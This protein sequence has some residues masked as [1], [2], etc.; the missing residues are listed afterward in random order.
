MSKGVKC[1]SVLT[2]FFLKKKVGVLFEQIA[3]DGK[4]NIN[5]VK[6]VFNKG[7]KGFKKSKKIN[8]KSTKDGDKC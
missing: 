5:Q 4:K 2:A 7:K 6:E 1:F 8:E 3:D